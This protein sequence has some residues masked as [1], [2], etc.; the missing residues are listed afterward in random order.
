M[1][2]LTLI[3]I[4]ALR[5]I[6]THVDIDNLYYF[7]HILSSLKTCSGNKCLLSFSYKCPKFVMLTCIYPY[8]CCSYDLCTGCRWPSLW[9]ICLTVGQEE[10]SVE[11][12]SGALTV[13]SLMDKWLKHESISVPSKWKCCLFQS[14]SWNQSK[15]EKDKGRFYFSSSKM[16]RLQR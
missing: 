12:G 3:F 2:V 10:S 8:V 1:L 13:S 16:T 14:V 4:D 6:D 15:I 11:L 7:I 5:L 9:G